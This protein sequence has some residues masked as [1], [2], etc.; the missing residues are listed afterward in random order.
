M[1]H[2]PDD[3][4]LV[5]LEALQGDGRMTNVALAQAAGISAPPCLRRVRA[6]EEAGIIRGYHAD[7][8][9]EKLGFSLSA[10]AMVGL[11][12]QSEADLTAFV[13]KVRRWPYVREA[14]VASGDIDFILRCLAPSFNDFQSFI[15]TELTAA[16][17]VESVRTAFAIRTAKHEAGLP[18]EI[19]RGD[20][21]DAEGAGTPFAGTDNKA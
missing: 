13:E 3:T 16:D 4:D 5:I 7:L 17:N 20:G 8:D 14:I 9:P 18:F 11:R 1:K 12:S 10:F 19:L 6:L 2:K 15:M 21:R